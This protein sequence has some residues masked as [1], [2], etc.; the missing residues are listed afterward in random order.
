MFNLDLFYESVPILASAAIVTVELTVCSVILSLLFGTISV[1]LQLSKIPGGY[2]L[3]RTYVSIMRGTPLLVQLFVVFFGL[4]L[5][6]IKG[7]AFLAAAVA[8][9]L[10][11][12]AYT[13]EILRAAVQNVPEGQIEAARAMGMSTRQIWFRVILPQ[14][15]VVSLPALTSEFTIVLK[16][17]PLA[18]V[19]AVTELTYAGVVIQARAF[20]AVEIF[21]PIAVGYVLIA[22]SFTQVSRWLERRFRLLHT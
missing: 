13:T 10:N 12:G 11:S 4:P 18:S 3:S 1:M 17:T 8:I 22:L 16:S 14:A 15:F 7:Q 5:L 6:G 19:V 21:L 2:W 20:S 9:G